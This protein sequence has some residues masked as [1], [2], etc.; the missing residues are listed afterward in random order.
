M[1]MMMMMTLALTLYSLIN[2][3][4]HVC[5]LYKL[6]NPPRPLLRRYRR[7]QARARTPTGMGKRG[8]LPLEKAKNRQRQVCYALSE[9]ATIQTC[10]N[11]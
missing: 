10:R 9:E 8:H 3:L 6:R 2:V 5:G 1:M 11:H 7:L 4:L